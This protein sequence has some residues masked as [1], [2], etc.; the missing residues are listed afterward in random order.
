[1]RQFQSL[2]VDG[3][4]D[5]AEKTQALLEIPNTGARKRVSL[6]CLRVE[7]ETVG[8]CAQSE[9]NRASSED[10]VSKPPDEEQE[11]QPTTVSAA[12]QQ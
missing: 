6:Q 3:S 11:E 12:K 4:G 5:G 10:L 1:M 9:S 7:A 2:G 8:A